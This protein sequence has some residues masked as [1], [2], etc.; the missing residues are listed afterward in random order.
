LKNTVAALRE[1]LE[2]LQIEYEDKIQTLESNAR[3]EVR[4]LHK[5]IGVLRDELEAAGVGPKPK[6]KKK[7][8]AK[9]KKAVTTRKRG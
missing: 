3:D 4:Q 1:Q 5:T 7:A 6:V 9:T 2:G 8:K